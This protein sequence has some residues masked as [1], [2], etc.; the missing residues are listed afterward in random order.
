MKQ[1]KKRILV[2]DDNAFS[3]KMLANVFAKRGY[4]VTTAENGR[5]A[6]AVLDHPDPPRLALIDWMMPEVDGV[7]TCRRIRDSEAPDPVYIILC[8][9]KTELKDIVIG[10]DAGANDYITK[11][12]VIDEL[13]ARV[14][15][16]ERVVEMQISLARRARDLQHALEHIKT[17][18]GLIPIC[19]YCHR[20]RDDEQIW[21]R[22]EIYLEHHSEAKLSHGLCPECEDK[23]FSEP[24]QTE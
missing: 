8:T 21:H 17:L 11:P 14:R 12:F 7:E 2:A 10:L 19:M 4:V 6:L 9:A 5:E 22:L 20:I 18:Q 3:R 13:L 23:H 1:T 16:G 15:V 24:L